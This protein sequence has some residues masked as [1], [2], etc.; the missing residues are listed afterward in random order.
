[1]ISFKRA[2]RTVLLS[3]ASSA[4]IAVSACASASDETATGDA[5]ATGDLR[6]VSERLIA[7]TTPVGASEV[8]ADAI[9]PYSARWTTANGAIEETLEALDDKTWRHT[10]ISYQNKDGAAIKVATETRTLSRTDLRSLSWSRKH[11]IESPKLPF[12]DVSVIVKPD[13]I[14]GEM[15]T[16]EGDKAPFNASMPMP[17]FDGWIAGIAIAALPLAEGYW[18]S[19]PTGTYLFK[20]SHHLKLTVVGRAEIEAANGDKVDTWEV[21]AEWVDLGS[22]DIYQPGA[23][24]S[25]GVYYMAVNPGDGVPYVVNYVAQQA[26]I[27]WDGERSDAPGN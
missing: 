14:Y 2:S 17:V 20:G 25:G 16:N 22:G 11:H 8:N 13:G 12:R 6:H 27:L 24:G 21:N 10:Q 5:A 15:T 18:A 7:Y 4:A 23:E 1:M 19:I 26:A 9:N 3:L